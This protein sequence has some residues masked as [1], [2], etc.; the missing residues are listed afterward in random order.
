MARPRTTPRKLPRQQ[1]SH[2]TVEAILEATR[3]A[4]VRHGYAGA[5]TARIA[6]LAGVSIGSLYQYFPSKDALLTA[7]SRRHSDTMG[8]LF[9][10]RL[11][12]SR[13]LPLREAVRLLIQTEMDALQ[14]EPELLRV[15]FD[16]A[17]RVGSFEHIAAVQARLVRM[18][19]EELAL[20]PELASLPDPGLTAFLLVHAIDGVCQAA[21]QRR[22]EL[23]LSPALLDAC[24]DLVMNHLGAVAPP[25][26]RGDG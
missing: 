22:P 12:A 19:A 23:V 15:L 26:A 24:T 21:L 3:R 10:E 1:R 25:P 20:R 4:L 8:A 17:P 2:E 5:T 14:E 11:V 7:L 18:T 6:E 16:Q 13:A 9:R